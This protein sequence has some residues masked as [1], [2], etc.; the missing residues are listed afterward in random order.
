[1][2]RLETG[3]NRLGQDGFY[4]LQYFILIENGGAMHQVALNR[5]FM[6]SLSAIVHDDILS[7]F[8]VASPPTQTSD[9]EIPQ[10]SPFSVQL[11]FHYII[12]D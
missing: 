3:F 7:I 4:L 1:L 11:R 6:G 10:T 12:F 2:S 9:G 5:R 8:R